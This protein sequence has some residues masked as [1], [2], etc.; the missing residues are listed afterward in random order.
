MPFSPLIT[1]LPLFSIFHYYAISL[2][3]LL[4]AIFAT[5]TLSL[6]HYLPLILAFAS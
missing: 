1:P 4:F 6:R 5:L 2:P 3:L